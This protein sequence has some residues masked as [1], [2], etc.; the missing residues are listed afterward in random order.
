MKIKEEN[1]NA[2]TYLDKSSGVTLSVLVITLI[3]LG[4]IAGTAIYTITKQPNTEELN[5]MYE[6]IYFL[7]DKITTYYS[8]NGKLPILENEI[9]DVPAD[10][11]K[12]PNDNENYYIIDLSQMENVSLSFGSGFNNYQKGN[13]DVYIVNEK[14]HQVYY[15][16]G[17][18]F[19]DKNYYTGQYDYRQIGFTGKTDGTFDENKGVNTPKIDDANGMELVKYEGNTWV[20]DSSRYSYSYVAGEGESDNTKSQWANARVTID[21]VESYFVWIPRYAYKITYYTDDTKTTVSDTNNGYGSIDVVFLK[22]KTDKYI[23]KDGN[24]KTAKRANQGGDPTKEYVVHPAFTNDVENGGWDKELTGI[25]VGKY[26]TSL[27]DK[28]TKQNI[29]TSSETEGNILLSEHTEKAIAVQPNVSSWRNITIGN[30]YT[31]ARYYLPNLESHMLKNSE[32]GAVAY[33]THSQYGRNGNEIDINTNNSYITEYGGNLSSSTGNV[34]GIYDL[35]GGAS[36]YVATYYKESSSLING[37]SFSNGV[38]DKYSTAYNGTTETKDYKKGDA[39][40]ET[41][42]WNKNGAHFIGSNNSFFRRGGNYAN[43]SEGGI[44]FYHY[45]NGSIGSAYSFRLCLVIE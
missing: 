10:M 14:S 40:F 32:W 8:K 25:W 1:I 30:M 26:E 44:F 6:D 42:K 20:K 34:Y 18:N 7:D 39:T 19:K 17:I 9:V 36:E 21:G 15:L 35:K 29:N 13:K 27:Y 5:N 41:K 3:V 4:I 16:K 43:S 11:E 33:L 24:E 31:N 28:E 45:I 2:I 12:N 38:S 23:D 37:N 22:G